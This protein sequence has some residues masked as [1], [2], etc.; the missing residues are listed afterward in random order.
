MPSAGFD[1]LDFLNRPDDLVLDLTEVWKILKYFLQ[2]LEGM[3]YANH[4]NKI[5]EH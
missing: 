2:T 3:F 5:T 4:C 1:Q